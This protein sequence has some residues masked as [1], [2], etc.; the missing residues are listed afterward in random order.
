MYR[1]A[2]LTALAALSLAGTAAAQCLPTWHA[3]ASGS[4]IP[5]ISGGLVYAATTWD[6]DGAGPLPA[7]A[8]IG[9]TFL[10]SGGILCN[11][12]AQWD[13]ASWQPLGTGVSGDV[14]TLAVHNG[15]LIAGGNF[16]TAG[17]TV[18][19]CIARYDG[20]TWRKMS[21]TGVFGVDG[22]VLA[23]AEVEGTL[24]VGGSFQH[25]GSQPASNIARYTTSWS[26]LGTGV[27]STVT[28]LVADGSSVIVGGDFTIADTIGAL[29]VAKYNGTFWSQIGA[30]IAGPVK[31]LAKFNNQIYAGG[32]F[33]HANGNATIVFG[34]TRW[35]GSFWE[36]VGSNGIGVISTHV[37]P[38]VTSMRVFNNRLYIGGLFDFAGGVPCNN[39]ASF[40]GT[41][42]QPL[43]AGV[44]PPQADVFAMTEHQGSLLAAG[45]FNLAGGQ[46]SQPVARWTGSQWSQLESLPNG[47][48]AC[49]TI[50]NGTLVAAGGFDFATAPGTIAHNAVGYT[51]TGT[52]G[53]FVAP[54]GST[55]TNGPVL[56]ACP[57]SPSPLLPQTTILA[58]QFTAAYG[59]AARNIVRLNQLSN[60]T[61][62]G[63]GLNNAVRTVGIYN[64]T[65]YAGG[66]FTASGAVPVNRIARFVGSAWQDIG[67]IAG[68][69]TLAMAVYNGKLYVGGDFTSAGG[70]S[71]GGLARWDGQAWSAIGGHFVGTVR[72]LTVFN[73]KLY[74]AGTFPG[75]GGSFNIASYD[76]S[77]YA[78][79]GDGLGVGGNGNVFAL[80]VHAG[81]LYAAG[82]FALPG[83]PTLVDLARFDGQAWHAVDTAIS[84][85]SIDAL[86]SFNNELWVGG[87]FTV[88]GGRFVPSIARLFCDCYANCDGSTTVPVLSANDFQCFLNAFASGDP[89]ANCDASAV[90]PVL[91]ANDFQCFLN[92]FATGCP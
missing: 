85:G 78:P 73:N 25:A 47:P 22:P 16:G 34:I 40:D 39:I 24:Y 50:S 6:P 31:V 67:G 37:S 92:R 71:T 56:A 74:I 80:A 60:P 55:G 59:I 5:D 62:L 89:Y 48:V 51:T 15:E 19:N 57:Q 64:N 23:L 86:Q 53:P 63:E 20:T 1:K 69:S 28:A 83:V 3:A 44:G 14:Y 52:V 77:T 70:L 58:G 21:T 91:T 76:G 43:D 68:G 38:R 75:I 82:S 30:G 11:R 49:M 4:V 65:L 36:P 29:R 46:A 18:V 87:S 88:I 27:N 84:G 8:V 35:N 26:S 72:A 9:G 42:F 7:R 79:V 90:L 81:E 33:A 54:G 45:A 17:G 2:L 32:S 10:T 66:D 12:I 13:G 61:A 41:T